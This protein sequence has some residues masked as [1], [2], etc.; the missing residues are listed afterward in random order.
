MSIRQPF[1]NIVNLWGEV[2]FNIFILTI[3]IFLLI[4][5]SVFSQN[6]GNIWYVGYNAGLDFNT[7]PPSALNDGQ[8]STTEGCATICDVNGATSLDVISSPNTFGAGCNYATNAQPIGGACALGLQNIIAIYVPTGPP[9]L[10]SLSHSSITD[11]SA[12]LSAN[13]I[14]DGGKPITARGFYYG[15]S[16]NPTGNQTLVAGTTGP[17]SSNISGLNP[18]VTYYYQAFAT[19][20]NGTNSIGDGTFTTDAISLPTVDT[21]TSTNITYTT[22][23]LGGNVSNTNGANVTERGLYWS[24]INGFTPPGQGTKVSENGNWGTGTFTSSVSGM[25]AGS[26]IYFKAFATNSA[27]TGY[28]NEASFSTLA[29]TTPGVTTT[30]ASSV[31]SR[32]AM[33]GGNVTSNGG[34]TVTARGVCWST[35]PAPVVTGNHTTDG[36]GLG[37]FPSSITGLIPLTT[38]Y[39]RAYAT[40][41]VGTSYGNSFTFQTSGEIPTATTNAATGITNSS[42]TINGTI[43]ANNDSTAVTFQ[44]GTTPAYGSTVTANPS[45]V[46]GISNTAVSFTLPGL[47]PNTTYHFRVVGVNG[48]GTM[49]GAGMT[50]TTS[51]GLPEVETTAITPITSTTA[52]GGGNVTYDGGS[53]VTARGICWCS[54]PYPTTSNSKTTDGTGKGIFTSS[55]NG[56]KPYTKYY[57][58]AYATNITGTVYG[59]VKTFTT[60]NDLPT[61]IITNPLDYSIV[62]GTVSIIADSSVT[63]SPVEFYIDENFLGNGVLNTASDNN[64]VSTTFN[65]NNS[66]YLFIDSNNYLK[67]IETNG[68]IKSVF[69][70]D[71]KVN[72]VSLNKFGEIFIELKEEITLENNLSSKYIKIELTNKYIYGINA[73]EP[74][75]ILEK[76]Y[77]KREFSQILNNNFES[78]YRINEVFDVDWDEYILVGYKESTKNY[79]IMSTPKS[80]SMD[81]DEFKTI[82]FLKEKPVKVIKNT[83]LNLDT[84]LNFIY[85][86]N[87]QDL[88]N[89]LSKNQYIIDWNTLDYPDGVY[90]IKVMALDK[91]NRT[92]S[93][94]IDVIIQNLKIG[95]NAIRK[96][97]RALTFNIHMGEIIFNVDN[98]NNL[99]VAKYVIQRSISGGTY[100]TLTEINGSDIVDNTYTYYDKSISSDSTYTYKV[101]AYDSAGNELSIS[102]EKSI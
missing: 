40:N 8:M 66:K 36:T 7:T 12:T 51:C 13:V 2:K 55:I 84:V 4:P 49:Y 29:L 22:A 57:V 15:T 25:P 38:Y 89:I 81:E 41:S 95:L 48:S 69:D 45:P 70:T 34:A 10:N 77:L 31:T 28:S 90:N 39:V 52:S 50:F 85:S 92:F 99:A 67:N 37:T 23:T 9:Q 21:P 47:I 91:Y 44:Y 42:A 74:E 61:I 93:D 94:E 43:N 11:I 98:P 19:N 14:S 100:E 96:V 16:P 26:T 46:T 78:D 30:T 62:D 20:S 58:R 82:T 59:N 80:G 73:P 64:S 18:G 3:I 71:I 87:S 1:R 56:L 5:F 32:T 102:E 54:S 35:S 6:R 60:L 33:S 83:I 63:A 72:D 65:I 75:E 86:K 68:N 53:Y 17:M 79:S 24:T 101:I 88:T 76:S 27:G 97:D